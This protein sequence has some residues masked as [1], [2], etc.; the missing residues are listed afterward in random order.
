M[1]KDLKNEIVKNQR[2]Y[3]K[4]SINGSRDEGSDQRK[5]VEKAVE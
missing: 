5:S 2:N 1:I 4:E 3:V